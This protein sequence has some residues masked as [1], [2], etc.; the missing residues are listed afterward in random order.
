MPE[1]TCSAWSVSKMK[2]CL[3]LGNW[4]KL[5]ENLNS[6]L[7]NNLTRRAVSDKKIPCLS[8]SPAMQRVM[9]ALSLGDAYSPAEIAERAHISIKSLTCASY[10]KVMKAQ[11]L[12]HIAGWAKNSNGFTTPLYAQGAN[13]DCPRPKFSKVDKDSLGMARIV[14]A[15]KN[16]GPMD[17][18]AL[19]L[20]SGIS[21]HTI[22]GARYMDALVVQKRVHIHDWKRNKNGPLKAIYAVGP[23]LNRPKPQ[24][25]SRAELSNRHRTKKLALSPASSTFNA[26]LYR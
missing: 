25:L 12:I 14:A 23:G 24:A 7:L 26:M 5:P 1:N 15:L 16:H 13:Q 19:A 17:Y 11:G 18:K 20:V 6:R 21:P 22:R 9:R 4:K 2:I 3:L 10:L 8:E